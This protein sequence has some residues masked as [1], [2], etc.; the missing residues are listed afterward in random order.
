MVSINGEHQ[1]RELLYAV[2]SPTHTELVAL[3]I[4]AIS[5]T[6]RRHAIRIDVVSCG[7]SG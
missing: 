4:A 5:P 6:R 2:A 7:W 3:P 1:W